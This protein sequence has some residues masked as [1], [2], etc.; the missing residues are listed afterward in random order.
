MDL[1]VVLKEK[2][3]ATAGPVKPVEQK[4]A[5]PIMSKLATIDLR[6]VKAASSTWVK[7]NAVK[8]AQ[9]L[10][11]A[12]GYAPANTVK[13]NK[14]D[15]IAGPGTKT[16]VVAFQKA[17]KLTADAMIGQNTWAKLLGV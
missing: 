11:V 2:P 4:G 15:G 5:D 3:T 9:G 1:D 12:R 17:N 13:N 16:A 14:V 8:T 7:G 10:L 6:G